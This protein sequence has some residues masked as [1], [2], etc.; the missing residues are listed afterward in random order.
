MGRRNPMLFAGAIVCLALNLAWAAKP[1]DFRISAGPSPWFEGW[2]DGVTLQVQTPPGLS[3]NY[4]TLDFTAKSG[5]DYIATAGTIENSTNSFIYVPLLDDGLVEPP[6]SFQFKVVLQGT[7]PQTNLLDVT[8][9]DNELSDIEDASF[10]SNFKP[11]RPDWPEFNRAQ[12]A[13]AVLNDGRILLAEW[14]PNR[15]TLLNTNGSIL[16][17]KRFPPGMTDDYAVLAV[18]SAGNVLAGYGRFNPTP[19]AKPLRRV[20]SDGQLDEQ[21]SPDLPA[22]IISAIALTPEGKIVLA[23][24]TSPLDKLTILRLNDD[25]TRDSSFPPVIDPA[26]TYAIKLFARPDN[27]AEVFT[28][29]TVDGLPYYQDALLVQ[30]GSI[31]DRLS[32]ADN[33]NYGLIERFYTQRGDEL[34][35]DKIGQCIYRF[36]HGALDTNFVA[37]ALAAD[38]AYMAQQ[39][40]GKVIA[41]LGEEAVDARLGTQ[42]VKERLVRF[43]TSINHVTQFR[44]SQDQRGY[45]TPFPSAVRFNIT[46]TG[47]TKEPATVHLRTADLT[48]RAGEDY[49]ATNITVEFP[50]LAVSAAAEITL[51]DD[52]L[53]ERME[54]FS[55]FLDNPES[56]SIKNGSAIVYILDDDQPLEL[57]VQGARDFQINVTNRTGRSVDLQSRTGSSNTW[58]TI[59]SSSELF[60]SYSGQADSTEVP[61]LFRAVAFP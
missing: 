49:V 55:V 43:E 47:D 23:F 30:Q 48:A 42:N 6:K 28:E 19:C 33:P 29:R 7:P 27:G 58:Q 59:R 8:I 61:I 16:E 51:L 35:I 24:T 31:R 13:A 20:W 41:L 53:P 44:L 32:F 39:A 1:E 15:I 11:I 2:H 34:V 10:V 26:A 60:W 36:A 17:M 18:G 25:G 4:Q 46:R 21:F 54:G 5:A 40:D 14:R 45:E 52:D 3:A 56:G 38:F 12:P 57:E 37:S 9:Y 50:P 22:G